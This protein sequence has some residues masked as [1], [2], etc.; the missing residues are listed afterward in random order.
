[1][2]QQQ[3]RPEN[4]Q[5]EES[6]LE[7]EVRLTIAARRE[8][9]AKHENELIAAFLDKVEHAVE[10]RVNQEAEVSRR[11]TPWTHAAARLAVSLVF[12]IPLSAIA[13]GTAGLPGLA[14]V[15]AG[16]IAL[17]VYFDRMSR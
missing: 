9:D 5:T 17:N 4:P 3:S 10:Q 8:L 13:A 14:I 7:E 16:I 12:G 6:Y 1:M 2:A 11:A 15:W